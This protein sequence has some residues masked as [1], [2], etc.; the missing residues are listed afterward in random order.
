M[1]NNTEAIQNIHSIR[2]FLFLYLKFF[3]HIDVCNVDIRAFTCD[4]AEEKM[5]LVKIEK[6]KQNSEMIIIRDGCL[7]RD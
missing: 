1:M 3:T 4:T 5:R 2:F 7:Q 6:T